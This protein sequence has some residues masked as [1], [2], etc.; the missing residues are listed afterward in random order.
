MC[1]RV[2]AVGVYMLDVCSLHVHYFEMNC[3]LDMNVYCVQFGVCTLLVYVCVH[4]CRYFCEKSCSYVYSL[5]QVSC[6]Y[7]VTL[8]AFLSLCVH[9]YCVYPSLGHFECVATTL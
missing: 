3:A 4:V 5:V 1:V 9:S 6:Q 2:C 7:F 8:S